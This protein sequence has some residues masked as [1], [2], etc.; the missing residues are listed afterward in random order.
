MSIPETISAQLKEAMR[1]RDSART[2]ALRM[3]KAAF[4]EAEKKAGSTPSDEDC[5]AVLR[6]LRKQRE[7]AATQYR[8]AGRLELAEGEE[9]EI[10][11]IDGFLP[12]L[13]DADTTRK[14][15]REAIE[16]SG[17]T[18]PNQLGMA[19]GALMRNHKGEVDGALARSILL[20]ELT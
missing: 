20:E 7:E 5:V 2:S 17:A 3:I 14:W 18:A 9:G 1:A 10:V 19:M 13:A 15:V 6:R 12:Q 8:E 4:L 11:V 16:S